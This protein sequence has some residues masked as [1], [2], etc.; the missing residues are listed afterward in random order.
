MTTTTNARRPR[1]PLQSLAR[2]AG[3]PAIAGLVLLAG[4][5]STRSAGT[6]PAAAVVLGS[7]VALGDSY[8]AGPE[9]P[10]PT[11]TPA[12]CLRSDRDYPAL[13]ARSLGLSSDRVHDASCS[14][15]D[16]A[17]LT[18][19]QTTG[20]GVNP[21]QLDSLSDDTTFVTI[22]ISGNDVDFA[23]V[24]TRCVELDLIPAAIGASASGTAPCRAYYTSGGTDQIQEKIQ[25]AASKLSD[26]LSQI[27]VRAPHARIFLVGY[28]DL[29]P[30]DGAT[31]ANTI[32]ITP[33]DIAYLVQEERRLNTALQQTARA[34]NATYVDTYTP[35]IGHDAC[36]APD[37]R[38][39]EPLAP[40][41][42]AAPL[43]PNARGE[44]GMADAVVRAITAADR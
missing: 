6:A 36:S 4:C 35:S 38:W 13:V 39:I 23:S 8:T 18:A 33:P 28:P 27:K 34:T 30:S 1:D 15:A 21:A 44:Q 41:S 24:L 22:G 20:D 12:G 19:P 25:N 40:A 43:H 3:I 17:D 7:Y 26:A 32:G 37:I 10:D 5:S 31:C 16:I 14:G 29:L 11:G 2:R 9:I 42:P